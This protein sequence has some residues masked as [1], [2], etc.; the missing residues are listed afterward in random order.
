M[1]VLQ[2]RF[3]LRL[4]LLL[5][6]AGVGCESAE[7]S[8]DV[9]PDAGMDDAGPMVEDGPTGLEGLPPGP[10]GFTRFAVDRE[11]NGPAF[12]AVADLNNDGR[13]DIV[14]GQFGHREGTEIP[15]G[16][17]VAYLQGEDLNSWE[18]IDIM[19]PNEAL[20][21][22]NDPTLE[23]VDGDGDIDVVVPGG[24]FV[25]SFFGDPCGSL[26]WYENDGTGGGW[27]PH[28][29]VPAGSELFYHRAE[30]A[31][32]DGDGLLDLI[33]SG[34]FFIPPAGEATTVWF[35]GT[36]DADRFEKTARII[37]EG[38]GSL[39][40]VLDL[41]GDGDLDVATAEFFVEGESA[42]WFE[43]VAEPSAENVDGVFVRHVID[44]D[45]GP[46]IQL[47]FFE[48]GGTRYALLSNHT[49]IHRDE[50]DSGV[51]L[52]EVPE[53][54]QAMM[55]WE[56]QMISEGIV[57]R[58]DE[59]LARNAAPG[60]FDIGDIDGDGDVDV[61]VS[62]DGDES[63]Y[64]LEQKS[65]GEWTTHVLQ[66]GFGQAGSTIITDLNG[67]GTNELIMSSYEQDAILV[68][69]AK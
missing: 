6:L 49:S 43:R 44:T 50:G 3:S 41:D 45:P 13:P 5:A 28:E 39:P 54:P 40:R 36:E 42:V 59:G 60:I 32:F 53:Q 8:V 25:C 1:H 61:L 11:A 63:V 66:T 30:L 33:T 37:G 62:G 64:W 67:D 20:A 19:P 10:D 38:G 9:S 2:S 15:P 35:K 14:T 26:F 7:P 29:I 24:F 55:K 57:S 68:F 56:G 12:S 69:R 16:R 47:S 58:P 31:D 21:W 4:L 27:T 52:Y 46:S 23:D 65:I 18:T 22:P 48:Q 51:F 17:V 34:E